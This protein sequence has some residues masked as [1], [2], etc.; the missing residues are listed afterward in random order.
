MWSSLLSLAED[1]SQVI[2][3]YKEPEPAKKNLTK[4]GITEALDQVNAKDFW[5][6]SQ[7]VDQF[8]LAVNQGDLQKS[9]R[10][11]IAFRRNATARVEI[12]DNEMQANMIVTGAY[13]GRALLAAEVMKALSDAHVTKGI[14]KLALRKVLMLSNNLAAGDEKIQPVAAGRL[15]LPGKDAIFQ[16]LVED[17][18]KRI[19]S[20]KRIAGSE[21]VD[22]RNLGETI[23][24]AQ[25]DELMRRI[26]PT[27]GTPG[28]TVTGNAIPSQPG[29]D[30]L[31]KAGKGSEISK[32]D[33]NL[34]IA[35]VS[36]LPILKDKCV[37]VDN[38]MCLKAIDVSTGHIKFKG[39]LVITG[40]VDPGMVVRATGSITIGGFVES[41]DVQAQGDILVGKGI[42][43]HNVEEGEPRSCIIKSGGMI[44]A[45]YA[46]YAELQS[47]DDMRFALHSLSN[48][49]RCGGDLLVVDQA[50]KNGTLSGG[51][52]KVGGKVVCVNL[53][54]E[55]DTPTFIEAF[56]KSKSYAERIEKMREAYRVAQDEMME[57]VRK[58]IEFKKRPR[59]EQDAETAQEI[60]ANKQVKN[61]HMLATKNGLEVLEHEFERA[62]AN[63]YIEAKKQLFSHVTV[64]FGKDRIVTKNTHGTSILTYNMHEIK[65]KAALTE[66]A[67]DVDV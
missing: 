54:V 3:S 21:R 17:V 22:M 63:N 65:V 7:A 48:E 1:G 25:G 56:A 60:D 62:L 64:V 24:V 5:L 20:P 41:A 30:A 42:I 61:E 6:D 38:A 46:Q 58:E 26:P 4:S 36:G 16:P 2:A 43:G 11:V 67:L 49:I 27:K 52:A 57:A 13:G 51:S 23:T 40:N 55:G 50:E 47:H 19:L 33:P 53:G 15:P 35:S 8:M 18:S 44:Q 45:N 9:Q 37:D 31:I 59:A 66:D 10:C 39:S 14:N 32:D 12:V 34:L 28:F 29:K